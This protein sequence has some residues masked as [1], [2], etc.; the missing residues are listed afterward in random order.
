M[1]PA[2]IAQ[3]IQQPSSEPAATAALVFIA[4]GMVEII[5]QLVTWATKRAGGKGEKTHTLLVQLDPEVSQIIH[6]TGDKVENVRAIIS[7]VD[8]DGMPL[9]YSDRKTER[10]IEKIAELFK[11]VAESQR[12]LA[13]MMQRLNDRFDSHDRADGIVF[14]RLADSQSRIEDLSNANN[15]SLIEF[16]RDH[17]LTLQK[18]DEVIKKVTAK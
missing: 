18:L 13:D 7:R 4:F 12:K 16:K 9:V 1:D 17:S 11:E 15:S 3:A 6:E 5:K 10:N 2:T 8:A 14:A